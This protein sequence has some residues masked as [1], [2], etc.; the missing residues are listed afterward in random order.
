MPKPEDAEARKRA[1]RLRARAEHRRTSYLPG[2]RVHHIQARRAAADLA[3]SPTGHVQNIDERG[4]VVLVDDEVRRYWNHDHTTAQRLLDE[5]G[6]E[7]R[8]QERWALIW[9]GGRPISVRQR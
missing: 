3:V 5:H 8:I 9:F 1:L 7:V 2:H 6:P 4:I